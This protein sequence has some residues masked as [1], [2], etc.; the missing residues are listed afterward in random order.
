MS[1]FRW[2]QYVQS[3][4][5]AGYIKSL[6]LDFAL[7]LNKPLSLRLYRYLDKKRGGATSARTSFAIGLQ[8]LCELHLGMEKAPYPSMLKQR[9]KPAHDELQRR[10][11]LAECAYEKMRTQDGEK[12]VYG[13]GLNL[14]PAESTPLESAEKNP[15]TLDDLADVMLERFREDDPD[16]YQRIENEAY[17]M[18]GDLDIAA[19]SR[20]PENEAARRT[21]QM[22]MR[23]IVQD[24]YRY[25]LEPSA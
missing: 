16:E 11:F 17:A 13:F 25:H 1:W 4:F 24:E 7:S 9:L 23:E 10:G 21:W 19:L 6:N 15:R 12:V 3:N 8:K 18:L 22:L 14:L 20:D 2:S 5:K